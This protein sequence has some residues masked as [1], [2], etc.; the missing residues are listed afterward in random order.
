[1]AFD[2]LL[3]VPAGPYFSFTI[4]ELEAELTN[5]K[6]ER[7]AFSSLLQASTV[8]GQNFQFAQLDKQR[9]AL[10]QRQNDLQVAFNYLD[11]GRF[12]LNPPS[13]SAGAVIRG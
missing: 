13:N 10:D 4:E 7:K 11:P 6:N 2:T 9:Q 12:P 1:M 5:Y 8:N 3:T